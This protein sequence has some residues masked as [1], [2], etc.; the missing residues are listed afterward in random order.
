[1][2]S[3]VLDEKN[4]VFWDEVCGSAFARQL[5]IVD[6]SAQSL[7]HFDR[8]YFELYPYLLKHIRPEEMVGKDVLE[9]GLGYGTVGQHLAEMGACYRGLDIAAGPVRMM[10]YRLRML[11]KRETAVQGSVL[12][13]PFPSACFDFVVAIGCFH[14]TGNVQRCIDETYRVLRP[15]GTAIVMV[16]NQ[17]SYRQWQKWP[18]R[19]LRTLCH[20]CHLVGA[21]PEVSYEQRRTY[22]ANGC[23]AAAPETV[24]ASVARLRRMFREFR[25]FRSWKENCDDLCFRGAPPIPRRR[26]LGNLGRLL[27][28]DIYVRA[29]K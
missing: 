26:L 14:H 22:D 11:G 28:L 13:C 17:F 27:G 29:D 19:T 1:M 8:Q 16:Y 25:R 21:G 6:H 18:L 24:F 20:E 5:G 7:R 9:V 12:D 2:Q 10:N 3:S 15:G 4:R 23:G